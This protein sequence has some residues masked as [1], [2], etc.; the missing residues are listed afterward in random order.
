VLVRN[1]GV[2]VEDESMKSFGS[3]ILRGSRRTLMA[4][5]STIALGWAS[6]AFGAVSPVRE[7]SYTAVGTATTVSI[8]TSAWTKVPATS[9]LTGRH[10]IIVDCPAA[11]SANVAAIISSNSSAPTEAT[12]VR[13]I[14][15]IRTE[16]EREVLV[17][18]GLHLYLL[19]LHTAAE[20]CHVQ[21][22]R[23]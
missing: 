15:I 17:G 4:L 21:E 13:P 8:S 20:S 12:T 14:E 7:Q 16:R 11:N 5:I 2:T 23:R 9:S 10:G 6:D 22:F 19:S 1:A 18:S 3:S